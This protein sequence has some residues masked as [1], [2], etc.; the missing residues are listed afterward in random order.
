VFEQYD[1]STQ[2]LNKGLTN[3][4]ARNAE[5][6]LKGATQNWYVEV[7]A[8]DQQVIGAIVPSA[9]LYN[10]YYATYINAG[11]LVQRGMEYTFKGT[12]TAQR[13]KWEFW[14]SGSWNNYS[15]LQ[16]SGNGR[17]PGM[18]LAQSNQGIK[19]TY[20]YNFSVNLINQWTDKTPL[21]AAQTEWAPARNV[22]N[23]DFSYSHHFIRRT[24][25]GDFM[26]MTIKQIGSVDFH[27]GINNVLNTTYTT[28][29]QINGAGGK[30]FN[31]MPGRNVYSGITLRIFL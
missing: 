31:P 1:Y 21:N 11:K 24:E 4:F 17:M 5:V 9:T 23:V 28:F 25:G 18:P 10:G 12:V 20:Q 19:I 22:M 15:L 16:A 26:V 7:N 30:Y 27:V 3:E 8:Y 14:S 2:N 6:G 29:Y 13:F